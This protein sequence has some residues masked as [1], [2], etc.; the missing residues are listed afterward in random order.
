MVFI[1]KYTKTR[2][3][4]TASLP[5]D[6]AELLDDKYGYNELTVICSYCYCCSLSG[7]PFTTDVACN[8]HAS[9]NFDR[10]TYCCE[11]ATATARARVEEMCQFESKTN[12]ERQRAHER[13]CLGDSVVDV[14]VVVVGVGVVARAVGAGVLLLAKT[15]KSKL[16]YSVD[17]VVAFYFN[18]EYHVGSGRADSSSSSSSRG[19]GR[20]VAVV[21]KQAS[22]SMRLSRAA[23]AEAEAAATT[24]DAKAECE[25]KMKY[26]S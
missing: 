23:E 1:L 14:V 22:S 6:R 12:G 25:T 17:S 11:R 15:A 7:V 13:T 24:D 5:A 8:T 19:G 18:F 9:T 4:F 20:R 21:R 3:I 26:N 10:A 2:I 16:K